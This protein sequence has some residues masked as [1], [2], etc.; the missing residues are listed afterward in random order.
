MQLA[1]VTLLTSCLDIK[2]LA[3]SSTHYTISL[4]QQLSIVVNKQLWHRSNAAGANIREHESG[5]ILYFHIFI[6]T[7][8]DVW[9]WAAVLGGDSD[10][11][12][13]RVATTSGLRPSHAAPGPCP[14]VGSPDIIIIISIIIIII[15]AITWSSL[16]H[17]SRAI[18]ACVL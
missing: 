17:C 13:R 7:D 14:R 4:L 3:Q 12:A 5:N 6:F 1:N 10:L 11:L 15:S 2:K 8:C 18:L 9:Y 16:L